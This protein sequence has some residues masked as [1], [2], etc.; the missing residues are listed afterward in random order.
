MFTALGSTSHKNFY[1]CMQNGKTELAFYTREILISEILS[2]ELTNQVPSPKFRAVII[3]VTS[4]TTK[5]E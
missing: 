4:S 1:M 2:F 3:D 5:P